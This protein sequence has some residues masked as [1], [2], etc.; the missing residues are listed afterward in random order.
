MGVKE[1]V[2]NTGLVYGGN[3]AKKTRRVGLAIAKANGIDLKLM[4]EAVSGLNRVVF[5]KMQELGVRVEDVVRVS[6]KLEVNLDTNEYSVED[7]E[8]GVWKKMGR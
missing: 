5:E 7:V 3:W 1:V 8:I 4:N 2:I 6:A